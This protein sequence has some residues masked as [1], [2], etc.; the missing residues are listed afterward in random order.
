M[1]NRR[2]LLRVFLFSVIL[3]VFTVTCKKIELIREIEIQTDSYSMGT[4]TVQ[5]TGTII[6]AGEGITGYG[7]YISESSP[8]QSGGE[9]RLVGSNSTTGSFSYD[10]T[11]LQGGKTYYYQAYAEDANEA[12]YGDVKNFSTA[13]LSLSTQAPIM[14]NKT[15]ATLNGNIDDLGFE[16]VTEYGFYWSNTPNPQGVTKLQV[17]SAGSTGAFSKTLS[18]LTIHTDYYYVAYA[19]N[20]S[21]TKY[22]NVQKFRIEN[23]WIRLNDFAGGGRAFAFAFSLDTMG[24]IGGG[25]DGNETFD[26]LWQYNAFDDNWTQETGSPETGTAFTIGNRAY[27][28]NWDRLYQFDPVQST[29]TEKTP[30]PGIPRDGVFAFGIADRGF[31]GSGKDDND[32]YF[33]DVWEFNPKDDLTN[34]IDVLGNPMGSWTMKTD[35]PGEGRFN[36]VGFSILD[37]EY[38]CSGYNET[39]EMLSDF[40]EFDPFSTEMGTW[41]QK[42]DYPGPVG[43]DL[44]S[45]IILNRAYVFNDELWQYNPLSDSWTRKADFPGQLRSDPVGFAIRTQGYMGTGENSGSYLNDFWE[46]IPDDLWD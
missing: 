4:G 18:G 38:V 42:T 15:S 16:A 8:P 11:Q 37:K 28:F 23:V 12:K 45:F 40:W 25:T 9:K 44:V 5:L 19:I 13:D 17:G 21:G 33:N 39:S 10:E 3:L 30:F 31:I 36:A 14:L 22:G 7:F 43:I 1:M 26:D 2:I 32:Q 29:W 6:D 24:Y 34:G 27:V 20:E 41:T 35:F 46:Y